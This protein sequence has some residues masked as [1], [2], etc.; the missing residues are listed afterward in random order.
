MALK[1]Q[2]RGKIKLTLK[3]VYGL[4]GDEVTSKVLCR[5]NTAHDEGSVAVD[6]SEE[7]QI[8]GVLD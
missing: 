8:A 5:V 1:F 2:D 3:E 6:A 4:V 7:L